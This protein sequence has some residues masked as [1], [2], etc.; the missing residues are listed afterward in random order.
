MSKEMQEILAEEYYR[1]REMRWMI[2]AIDAKGD[3]ERRVYVNQGRITEYR[4]MEDS[5][6]F[7]AQCEL[8]AS[9]HER[10]ARHKKRVGAIRRRFKWGLTD[11]IKSNVAGWTWSLAEMFSGAIGPAIDVLES[12]IPG[13]HRRIARQRW[14]ARERT[15][16]FKTEPQ[17]PGR[18]LRRNGYKVRADTQDEATRKLY[19]LVAEKVWE[20]PPNYISMTIYCDDRPLEYLN[21]DTLRQNDDPKRYKE[22][23]TMR[24]WPP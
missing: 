1:D 22:T 3:V 9:M 13:R 12:V 15:Y 14:R 20:I 19:R 8:L 23:S 11:V 17:I 16:W 7:T 21:L 24:N 18:R 2:C 4:R 5:V 10:D 6:T